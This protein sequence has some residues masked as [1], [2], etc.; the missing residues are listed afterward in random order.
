MNCVK[1]RLASRFASS[2]VCPVISSVGQSCMQLFMQSLRNC[3]S[4]DAGSWPTAM[5]CVPSIVVGGVE[6]REIYKKKRREIKKTNEVTNSMAPI[7]MRPGHKTMYVL[8][9]HKKGR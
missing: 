4:I 6:K 5:A 8:Y 9:V 3:F 2:V 1:H 7:G